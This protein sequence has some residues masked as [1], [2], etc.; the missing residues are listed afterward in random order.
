MKRRLTAVSIS[1][2]VALSDNG[3]PSSMVPGSYFCV[4]G[5]LVDWPVPVAVL[6]I[7]SRC[8]GSSDELV[9]LA[10]VEHL[11]VK[12]AMVDVLGVAKDLAQGGYVGSR[13]IL[14]KS[15]KDPLDDIRSV[16]LGFH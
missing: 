14:W 13:L 1:L 4:N 12:G 16:F 9:T 15:S 3:I 11:E 6:I 5:D 10:V 8:V 2:N 7:L